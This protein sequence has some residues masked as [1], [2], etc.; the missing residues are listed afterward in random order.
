VAVIVTEQLRVQ[1][2]APVQPS[3]TALASGVAV[4]VMI[5][6]LSKPAVQAPVQLIAPDRSVD[7]PRSGDRHREREHALPCGRATPRW[8]VIEGGQP[9]PASMAGEPPGSAIVQV[10]PPLLCSGLSDTM[11]VSTWLSVSAPVTAMSPPLTLEVVLLAMMVLLTLVVEPGAAKRPPSAVIARLWAR[12][13]WGYL[14]NRRIPAVVATPRPRRVAGARA[15]D[16]HQRDAAVQTAALPA[17]AVIA[18]WR[19]RVGRAGRMADGGQQAGERG[20]ADG[21]VAL[22]KGGECVL[23]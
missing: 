19:Q 22:V 20:G 12:V 3:N 5:A 21:G 13:T 8:S 7:A 17:R 18:G 1:R 15:V 14:G 9:A 23:S 2:H 6:P 16:Q 11:S 4:R 10:A